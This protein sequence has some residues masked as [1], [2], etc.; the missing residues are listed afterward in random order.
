MDKF[1]AESF[2]INLCLVVIS[3]TVATV[4]PKIALSEMN[5]LSRLVVSLSALMLS[6]CHDIPKSSYPVALG[7]LG[8]PSSS[9]PARL[10]LSLKESERK[11]EKETP[12]VVLRKCPVASL[13]T[14]L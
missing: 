6:C 11:D 4:E 7:H 9:V 2:P 3:T 10:I 8:S 1:I 13:G 5:H 12:G 14:G